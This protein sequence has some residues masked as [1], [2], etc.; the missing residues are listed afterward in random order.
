MNN[1]KYILIC[2]TTLIFSFALI[3]FTTMNSNIPAFD[4][5]KIEFILMI[6]GSLATFGGALLGAKLSGEYAIRTVEKRQEIESG[7]YKKQAEYILTSYYNQAIRLIQTMREQ[8]LGKPKP[9]KLGQEDVLYLGGTFREAEY[10]QLDT[11]RLTKLNKM[12]EKL[13]EFRLSNGFFY[14]ED[15]DI[16]KIDE[17]AELL[18]N[19][20]D[21]FINLNQMKEKNIA[22][23]NPEFDRLKKEAFD[24]LDKLYHLD[25][26]LNEKS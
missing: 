2:I 7:N 25:S 3:F 22:E 9:V 17:L 21:L 1:N 14:L 24:N 23:G 8:D 5:R 11:Y 4:D 16:R 6:I 10:K 13:N 26:P 18:G 15:N 19:V 12:V 20:A